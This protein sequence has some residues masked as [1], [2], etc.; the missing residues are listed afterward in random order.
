D[1]GSEDLE[2]RLSDVLLPFFKDH[3]LSEITV[4]E[5]DRFRHSKV[6]ERQ[7]IQDAAAKGKPIIDKYTDSRGRKCR[8]PRRALSN[9]SINKVLGTLAAILEVAVEY[10][11][12]SANPARGRRRQLPSVT[13]QRSWL[14]RA[15]HIEAMLDA[16]GELDEK[17]TARRGQRR[18]LLAV[19]VY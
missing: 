10:K 18:A 1:A 7:E 4:A 3:L 2:W 17:A 11:H 16:A 14:D 5:V 9:T 19:L 12:L 6:R 15:E 8:R 13:P